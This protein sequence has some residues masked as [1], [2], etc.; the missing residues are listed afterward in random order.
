MHNFIE[1]NEDL[2]TA[3]QLLFYFWFLSRYPN[4]TTVDVLAEKRKMNK[5]P[6][7]KMLD[8]LY[9]M[10]LVRPKYI[11]KECCWVPVQKYNLKPKP[12]KTYAN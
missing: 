12:T 5:R 4:G 8:V 10:K 6:V 9:D 2:L 3:T 11:L 7:E 1:Q